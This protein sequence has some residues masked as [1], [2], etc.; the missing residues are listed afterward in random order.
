MTGQQLRLYNSLGRRIEDFIPSAD[1]VGMYSCGPTVYSYQHL[2]NMRP[3]V[4]ADTLRRAFRWKSIP[5][6]AVI[7]ITDVGHAVADSNTGEDKLEVAAAKE[8]RSVEEIAEFYTQDWLEAMAAL[9][10]QPADVYPRAS[11]YVEEMIAFAVRLEELGY[12][13]QLPS[14]LYF[15]TSKSP[16]YGT[17][18]LLD[19]AGQRETGRIEH[20]EGRKLGS[21]FAL[22][23]A[24]EPGVRRVMRWNSPWGWG[25]PGWHLECS[26]MSMELLGQHFD[27]H[28]GGI[29]HRELHHVNEIAQSEAFLHDGRPWVPYWLHNEFILLDAQKIAK[30][31]GHTLRLA[32]LVE[33]GYHP[34]AYRLFLLGGHYRSQLDFT[35][36]AMDATQVTLRR[37]ISRIEPLRPLPHVETLADATTTR[38]VGDDQAALAYVEAIDAAIANDLAT[39]KLLATLQDALHD[40][41]IS[42]AGL[43][44]VVAAADALLGLRLADLDLA[45]VDQRRTP[46]DL[47][48]E[49]VETIERLIAERTQARKE[50]NWPRADEIRAELDALGVQVTDTPTGPTWQ[51]S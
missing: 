8:R 46:D 51:L 19:L 29:D 15:D 33:W 32:D 50:K 13:Y 27:L 36:T 38:E 5:V 14:G 2:G 11:E 44:V 45:E 30:S 16:G 26:V 24:E 37:L 4:F 41:H 17:L 39:P 20:V 25:A 22:W 9:N 3:Y 47:A 1:V 12:T 31:A 23:R 18:A 21:D 28:T 7:N 43:R 34:M 10:V 6:R 40:P 42:L 48:P 49:Q 35:T